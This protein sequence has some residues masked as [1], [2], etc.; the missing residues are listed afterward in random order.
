MQRR[1]RRALAHKRA[2]FGHLG[3]DHGHH[4]K[5]V[6]RICGIFPAL[7]GLHH[8]NAHHLAQTLDRDTKEGGEALLSGLWHIAKATRAGGVG[9]V[10]DLAGARHAP[11]Q[12]LAHTHTGLVNGFAVQTFSG[13]EFQC[14]FVAKQI[15]GAHFGAHAVGNQL[16]DLIKAGLPCIISCHGLAQTTQKLSAFGFRVLNHVGP[17]SG[18]SFDATDALLP[19]RPSPAF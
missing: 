2:K 12:P 5:R 13:A 8:Q 15:D 14:F 4:L 16:S 18:Y 1:H 3:N 6:D 11:H 9:G 19:T 10:D 7:L 17:F